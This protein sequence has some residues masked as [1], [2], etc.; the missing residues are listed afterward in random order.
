MNAQISPNQTGT[1]VSDR[2]VNSPQ[3][4]R[5]CPCG[6][7]VYYSAVC[8]HVYQ[9]VKFQCGAYQNVEY[10]SGNI[11]R[12]SG[13]GRFCKTPAPKNIVQGVQIDAKCQYY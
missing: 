5:S 13:R 10:E 1:D 8:G 12:P 7:Y 9:E 4:P 3:N 6:W 2:L 11:T